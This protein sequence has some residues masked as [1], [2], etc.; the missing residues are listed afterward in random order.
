M[1]KRIL[2]IL[3]QECGGLHKA[4]VVLAVSSV[5]SGFLGL[6]RDLCFSFTSMT[7]SSGLEKILSISSFSWMKS[8]PNSKSD[9]SSGLPL[10]QD[11][12]V[13]K[14]SHLKLML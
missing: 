3:H 10:Q 12:E 6:F 7:F 4:A 8:E 9:C 1:V 2:R 11:N 13:K 5:I 14:S